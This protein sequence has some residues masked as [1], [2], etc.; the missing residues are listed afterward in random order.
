VKPAVR[1]LVVGVTAYLL[2]LV[3]TVPAT[4]IRSTLQS[5][6]PELL[7]G[8]LSGTVFS[9]KVGQV[10]F[11]DLELGPVN[12][13]FRPL[14]VLLLRIEYRLELSHPDSQGHL[15]LGIKPGGEIYGKAL[16]I[17]LLPDRLINQFSPVQLRSRGMLDL[18]LDSFEI[19]GG[20]LAA[21]AGTISWQDAAIMSPLELGLG[22]LELALESRDDYLVG[23]VTRGG[24]LG[25]SGDIS[26]QAGGGYTLDLVLRPGNYV[27]SDTLGLLDAVTQA[28]PGGS[29]LLKS[30]GRL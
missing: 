2:F 28:G 3:A 15:I 19:A 6:V 17:Q 4:Y 12:W 29:Y 16:E 27:D 10:R 14:A 22:Q 7:L 26:I 20:Q 23:T 5:Q 18:R 1:Y 9:G 11:Q 8:K 21:V 25:A 30:S 24:E 13:H